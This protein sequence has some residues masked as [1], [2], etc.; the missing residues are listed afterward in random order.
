MTIKYLI[1]TNNHVKSF[2]NVNN[3][4]AR[5]RVIIKYKS[6]TFN[7]LINS[8]FLK[9]PDSLSRHFQLKHFRPD[10]KRQPYLTISSEKTPKLMILS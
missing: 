10:F 5:I 3:H 9:E 4:L 7:T 8:M 1:V 6:P 2:V